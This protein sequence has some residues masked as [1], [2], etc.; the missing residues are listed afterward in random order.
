ML[1]FSRKYTNKG[2]R[3][4]IFVFSSQEWSIG[5]TPVAK[6]I[7]QCRRRQTPHGKISP[8]VVSLIHFRSEKEML[9]YLSA[10]YYCSTK[11]LSFSVGNWGKQMERGG[12][13]YYLISSAHSW[14]GSPRIQCTFVSAA[15]P[16]T[17]FNFNLTHSFASPSKITC[18]RSSFEHTIVRCSA[19][20]KIFKFNITK[21]VNKGYR[22]DE[23]AQHVENVYHFRLSKSYMFSQLLT[24]CEPGKANN[25]S[26]FV[27]ALF[28]V[29]TISQFDPWHNSCLSG[30]KVLIR[31][32]LIRS[33]PRVVLL[34]SSIVA[35]RM[36]HRPQDGHFSR[37]NRPQARGRPLRSDW[38][39]VNRENFSF[40]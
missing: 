9:S 35:H 22:V 13:R 18:I 39:P 37:G 30:C 28:R 20:N 14:K 34:P 19:S 26:F 5:H 27:P 25:P 17:F 1:C 8:F 15:R 16:E 4:L 38:P 2:L 7:G 12:I 31:S 10:R 21:Y 23:A 32:V 29:R 3:K 24:D 11:K 33:Y 40:F 36:E 6:Q